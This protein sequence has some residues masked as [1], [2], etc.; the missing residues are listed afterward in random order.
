MQQWSEAGSFR[1]PFHSRDQM[2]TILEKLGCH[3]DRYRNSSV[4]SI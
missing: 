3:A 4:D 1:I 2:Q